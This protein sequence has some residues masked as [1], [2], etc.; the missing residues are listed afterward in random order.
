MCDRIFVEEYLLFSAIQ[1]RLAITKNSSYV[2]YQ[3]EKPA[4]APRRVGPAASN[5]R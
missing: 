2:K 1:R 5:N 4:A 3:E